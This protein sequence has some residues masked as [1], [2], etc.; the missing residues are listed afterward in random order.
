MTLG[1]DPQQQR[2][3]GTWIGSMMTHL[4]VYDG[5]LDEASGVL[6]LEAEGPA[7]AGDGTMARYRDTIE[8]RSNDHRVMTS[9]VLGPDG[10]AE[11]EAAGFIVPEA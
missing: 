11:L 3:V 1:Y 8:F 9:S 2:Y 7:M 6:T 10:R 4:W 5:E